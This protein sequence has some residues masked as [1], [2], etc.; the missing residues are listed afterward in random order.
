MNEPHTMVEKEVTLPNGV[1]CKVHIIQG[2]Q[3]LNPFN[4]NVDVIVVLN[5]ERPYAATFFTMENIDSIMKGYGS[6]GECLGGLYFWCKNMIIVRQLDYDTILRVI[7]DLIESGE[8]T[9]A[10]GGAEVN[11]AATKE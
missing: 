7:A 11:S 10:F 4:D 5:G 9:D 8:F 3:S 2:E 1:K 6:S